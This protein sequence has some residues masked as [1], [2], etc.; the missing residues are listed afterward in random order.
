MQLLFPWKSN[1]YYTFWVRVC[2]FSYPAF[3]AHASYCRLWPAQLY[4]IFP[5][6]LISAKIFEKKKKS[7][8]TQNMFWIS[9]QILSDIYQSKNNWARY[10][11]KNVYW[12]SCKVPVILG[13]FKWNLIFGTVFQRILK[14][15]SWKCVQ[16]E[17]SYSM[18]IDR[19]TDR[20]DEAN[21]RLSQFCERD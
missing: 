13:R 21:R 9:L 20:H 19:R 1:K 14:Y 5:H 10:D 16:W 8:W 7:Y 15:I 17:P 4:F 18:R 3:N 11:E 2:S 12:S 6:N